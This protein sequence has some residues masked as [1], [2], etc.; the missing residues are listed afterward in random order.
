[1]Y[2]CIFHQLINY[3]QCISQSKNIYSNHQSSKR[4]GPLG[5]GFRL[6]GLKSTK[7][8]S[9]KLKIRRS[10]YKEGGKARQMAAA[11]AKMAKGFYRNKREKGA[12]SVCRYLREIYNHE[13][14]VGSKFNVLFLYES[15]L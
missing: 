11:G 3:L 1:M 2:V 5:I 10:K 15:N 7:K 6:S 9:I 8:L 12:I 13:N 4:V 14:I